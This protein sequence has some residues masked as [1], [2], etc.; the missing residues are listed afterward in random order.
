MHKESYL[1]QI[2]K[3]IKLNNISVLRVKHEDF[4]ITNIF[5][6]FMNKQ[7]VL[8]ITNFACIGKEMIHK[9]VFI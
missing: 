3:R 2:D 9:Y 8:C 5:K 1:L 7:Y 4:A 6:N